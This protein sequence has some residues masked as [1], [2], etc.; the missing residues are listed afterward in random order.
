MGG[1]T[2]ER[3]VV[4]PRHLLATAH[5][6]SIPVYPRVGG[7]TFRRR[8]TM[9]CDKGLSPRGRGNHHS[10]LLYPQ[11]N[12]SIPA[13]AGE[14]RPYCRGR[15]LPLV[16]PRVGGGTSRQMGSGSITGL[17]PRGRGNPPDAPPSVVV[18]R[19]YPRVGGG[20]INWAP[21]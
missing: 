10:A 9:R 1:G 20:T 6:P 12:G 15:S 21:E 7:G 8:A 11:G 4:Y 5:G 13:W 3:N 16:Y 17:S 19:V 18:T 14:P 2:A